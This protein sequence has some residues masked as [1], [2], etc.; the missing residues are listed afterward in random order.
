MKGR[1]RDKTAAGD[2]S[3]LPSGF[4]FVFLAILAAFTKKEIEC[5]DR[6]MKGMDGWC[7]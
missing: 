5:C 3:S 7:D 2:E 1:G 4:T 6:M